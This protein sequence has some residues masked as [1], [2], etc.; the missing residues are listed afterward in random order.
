MARQ[1]NLLRRKKNLLRRK[2]KP[3]HERPELFQRGVIR[4]EEG[5]FVGCRS[6]LTDALPK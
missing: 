5:R 4:S 3:T 1:N 2:K 6:K